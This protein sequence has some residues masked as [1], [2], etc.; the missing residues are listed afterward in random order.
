MITET[1]TSPPMLQDLVKRALY[2]SGLLGLVHR[3]RNRHTLT[4]IMFHRVLT[5]DDPRWA[6]CDP[7]YTLERRL[8][9]DCLAFFR[10][11]YH[12]VDVE[13]VLAA[14]RGGAPLPPR[15]LLITFDDGWQDN[16]DHALP[17]LR[18]AGLPGVLF[19]VADA[20]GRGQPFFQERLVAAWRRGT[21]LVA[22]LH[23][24]LV[25]HGHAAPAGTGEDVGAL[26]R[27]IAALEAVPVAARGPLLAEIAPRLDDGLRHMVDDG[28][29]HQLRAGGV[30]IGLHG[31]TH[32]PMTRAPDLD[33]ELAG[34]R[35]EVGARLCLPAPVTMSFPHGRFDERI[36]ARAR[37]AGYEL[38]FTSVPALNA[39]GDGPGWLLARLGFETAAIVDAHGRFRPDL[40]ALYLFRREARRLA[41]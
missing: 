25:A 23:A 10:R 34:A 41:A 30:E 3:W 18:R 16:V 32:E 31:K 14:R 22:D 37:E 35:T 19:L 29:L 20:V 15:A 7:D 6:S 5:P 11:H 9:E 8:F 17:A 13:A 28:E 27:A 12:V 40:L 21:V 26:R 36:A 1:S 4:V 39:T 2:G 38:V 33:A 24:L